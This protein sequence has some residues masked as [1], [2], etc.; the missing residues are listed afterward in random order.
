MPAAGNS[1]GGGTTVNA[2]TLIAS[3]T[4]GSATGTGNVTLNGGI[5]ASGAT[6]SISGNV[7]PAPGRTPS[8]RA[9]SEPSAASPSV[10]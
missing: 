10:D 7:S 1:Y 3:N 5:L 2:G 6:G 9:E 8:R 4:S